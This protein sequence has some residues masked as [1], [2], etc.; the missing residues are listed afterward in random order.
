[1]AQTLKFGWHRHFCLCRHR[2]KCLCHP[3][4]KP[5]RNPSPTGRNTARRA[6]RGASSPY[7]Q[8]RLQLLPR[9]DSPGHFLQPRPIYLAHT[10]A[11][12]LEAAV[13]RRQR[14]PETQ[15]LLDFRRRPRAAPARRRAPAGAATPPY[16]S[17][18]S[19]P[20]PAH[21]P[22]ETRAAF[23]NRA[24]PH[25]SQPGCAERFDLQQRVS[26]PSHVPQVRPPFRG[27]FD[28]V[29]DLPCLAIEFRRHGLERLEHDQRRRRRRHGPT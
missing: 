17:R 16:T 8:S 24:P 20:C 23:A 13:P 10:A 21:P 26:T 22:P 4:R 14:L 18:R 9:H 29:S 7:A 12:P 28:D 19:R 5:G 2:Q 15:R 11:C 25:G 27:V 6:R 1:M 3:T